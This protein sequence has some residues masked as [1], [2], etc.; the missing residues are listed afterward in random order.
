MRKRI[1]LGMLWIAVALAGALMPSAASG[2]I[3]SESSGTF[4]LPPGP[5]SGAAEFSDPT[6]SF[7]GRY[8]TYGRVVSKA[9]VTDAGGGT[10]TLTQIRPLLWNG[11][12]ADLF[13][14]KITDG[15]AF[16]ASINGTTQI[17]ALFDSSGT[18]LG[19][20]RGG[21]ATNALSAS[22]IGIPLTPGDYYIGVAVNGGVPRNGANQAIF[23][24]S[25]DG[26]KQPLS[27]LLGYTLHSDPS[28]AWTVNGG[29]YLLGSS[30]FNAGAAAHISLSGSAF[31]VP[32][33]ASLGSLALTCW[34]AGRRRRAYR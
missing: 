3:Y 1:V 13:K 5:P 27:G 22:A 18:A 17:L 12:D 21:G 20:S 32:E 14:F 30:S 6:S 4:S 10:H 19:A 33:P 24:F 7:G 26:V 2:Q 25:T 23:D 9:E 16:S 8:D 34:L 11:G 28:L 15:A 31:A 29:T